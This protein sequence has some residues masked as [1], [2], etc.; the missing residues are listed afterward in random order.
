M[1]RTTITIP[2]SLKQEMDEAGINWGSYIREAVR[3]KLKEGYESNKIE[4]VILNERLRKKAPEG[5]D[6]T[7]VIKLWRKRRS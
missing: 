1:V 6:S 5:W 4:A 3:R 7:Q 2:E